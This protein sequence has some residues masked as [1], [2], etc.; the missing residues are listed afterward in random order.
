MECPEVN[1]YQIDIMRAFKN[2]ISVIANEVKQSPLGD[3]RLA[4]NLFWDCF[5][6]LSLMTAG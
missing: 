1:S 3:T 4:L 2:A 6:T 5:R